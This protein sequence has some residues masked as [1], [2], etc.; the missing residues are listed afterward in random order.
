MHKAI[1]AKVATSLKQR[2]FSHQFIEIESTTFLRNVLLSM[3]I[4]IHTKDVDC[5]I[6]NI[7]E[8]NIVLSLICISI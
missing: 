4:S 6:N 5:G 8:K 2:R 1:K 3:Y 7:L